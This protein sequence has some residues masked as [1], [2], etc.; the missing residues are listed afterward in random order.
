MKI[1]QINNELEYQQALS[2]LEIIFD[3]VKNTKEGEE[4]ELISKAI[5]EYENK[6]YPLSSESEKK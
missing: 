1:V 6:M 3:S 5:E 4:L 2:R